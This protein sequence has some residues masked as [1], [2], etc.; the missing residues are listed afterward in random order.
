M[1]CCVL[2]QLMR[3]NDGASNVFSTLS[4]EQWAATRKLVIHV[5]LGTDMVNHFKV[6]VISTVR[7]DERLVGRRSENRETTHDGC[8]SRDEGSPLFS[9]HTTRRSRHAGCCQAFMTRAA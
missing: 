4:H 5:I 1:H 3:D 8:A 9:L 6:G 2:Y 7:Q